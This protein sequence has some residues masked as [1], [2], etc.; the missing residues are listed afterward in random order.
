MQEKEEQQYLQTIYLHSRLK[1]L[2]ERIWTQKSRE[3]GL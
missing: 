1:N 3:K 2:V